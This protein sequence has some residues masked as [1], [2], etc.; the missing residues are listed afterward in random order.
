M[1]EARLIGGRWNNHVVEF[2]AIFRYCEMQKG[3]PDT[4]DYRQ[5][6]VLQEYLD[7][8]KR[9]VYLAISERDVKDG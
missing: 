1:P 7:S 2:P 5:F 9:L 4:V 3:K 6:Y 8:E